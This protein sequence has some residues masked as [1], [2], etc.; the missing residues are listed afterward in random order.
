MEVR[1]S[2]EIPQLFTTQQVFVSQ[3][4]KFSA[5]PLLQPQ[6]SRKSSFFFFPPENFKV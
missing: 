3:S 6:I 1:I 4:S 2:S 5:K